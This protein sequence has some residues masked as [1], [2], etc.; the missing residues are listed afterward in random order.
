MSFALNDNEVHIWQVDLDDPAWDTA[1]ALLSPDERHRALAYR[2]DTLRRRFQHGRI[3]LRLLLGCYR[4]QAPAALSFVYNAFGKPALPD[5]SLH[6]NV[7]HS[8][9]QALIALA[10]HPVGIDIEA[11]TQP[12]LELDT[13]LELVCHRQEHGALAGLPLS[14]RMDRFLQLW[15]QKEAYCKARGDGLQRHLPAIRLALEPPLGSVRV[16]DE[17][18]A[19]SARYYIH[20]LPAPSGYHASACLPLP[21][22]RLSLCPATI[23]LM[24]AASST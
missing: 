24:P 19:Q 11:S 3:A 15:T 23:A 21:A 5:S 4:K 22:P 16:I 13:L 2:T 8:Q 7:S 9:G 1:T 12:R 17:L 14:A 10:R 20:P 18:C 6:F